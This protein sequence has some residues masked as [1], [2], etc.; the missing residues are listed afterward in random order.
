MSSQHHL[1]ALKLLVILLGIV[2]VGGT[3]L[4]GSAVW[5]KISL[6]RNADMLSAE[7][8]PGGEIDLKGRGII[9]E[10]HTEDQLLRLTLERKPGQNE[11]LTVDTCTGKII[12]SLLLQTDPGMPAAE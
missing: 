2:L 3:V 8:C 4:L 7:E 6:M 10:S 1:T 11:I 12:G 9:I 5:K